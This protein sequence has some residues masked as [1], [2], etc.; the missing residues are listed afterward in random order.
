M[1]K[2]DSK[3]C[4]GTIALSEEQR[5]EDLNV[6]RRMRAMDMH[7]KLQCDSGANVSC[8][9]HEHILQHVETIPDYHIG[10]IGKGIKCTK[11][12]IFYIQ[13]RGGDVISVKMYFS[14]EAKETV[15]SSTDTVTSHLEKFDS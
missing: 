13:C 12:G 1:G 10:G 3:T 7:I 8:T 14:S 4:A 9:P 6:I 2:R 11:S 5:Q 15:V